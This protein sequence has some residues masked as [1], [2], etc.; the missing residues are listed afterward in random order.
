MDGALIVR[1]EDFGAGVTVKR[2]AGKCGK[3]K[4][5]NVGLRQQ[6]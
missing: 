6:R 3:K 1:L 5:L 2:W 4:L